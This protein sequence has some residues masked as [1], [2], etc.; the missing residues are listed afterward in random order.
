MVLAAV[1]ASAS[2][3]RSPCRRRQDLWCV[4]LVQSP[5]VCVC[6][7]AQSLCQQWLR[8]SSS[9]NCYT[10]SAALPCWVKRTVCTEPPPTHRPHFFRHSSERSCRTERLLIRTLPPP[11]PPPRH[12][13]CALGFMQR[14]REKADNKKVWWPGGDRQLTA[15]DAPAL[16]ATT[17]DDLRATSIESEMPTQALV[18][19]C[20]KF[21]KFPSHSPC[22]R[23]LSLA[24]KHN[25]HRVCC[26]C[27]LSRSTVL[28][29]TV[30]HQF[31]FP[32]FLLTPFYLLGKK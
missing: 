4:L 24:I 8:S 9:E 14:K 3:A 10:L 20:V 32:G 17:G 5:S 2:A 30:Y 6:V 21:T 16:T 7:C 27:S 28:H 25:N 1:A 19:W 22:H 11:R 12:R 15:H 23:P 18:R 26:C 29:Q 13:R 31:Y